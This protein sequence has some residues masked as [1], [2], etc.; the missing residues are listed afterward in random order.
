[1]S[2]KACNIARGFLS[3]LESKASHNHQQRRPRGRVIRGEEEDEFETE[4]EYSDGGATARVRKAPKRLV[5]RYATCENCSE[6]FDVTDNRDD[7]STWHDGMD[8]YAS[9]GLVDD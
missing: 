8:L 6:D 1:M 3:V 4:E 7:A 5:A 9:S 2:L